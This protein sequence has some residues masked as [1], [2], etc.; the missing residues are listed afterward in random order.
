MSLKVIKTQTDYD[1]ALREIE[2]LIDLDPELGTKEAD[3]LEVL[4]LLIKAYENEQFHFDLPDPISAIKFVM[5][6]RG[7]KQADLVPFIGSRPKVSEILSGK[8][9]LSLPMMRRLH[10]GLN[11]PAEI[12]LREPGAE[13]P[14]ETNIEW[15]KLP[16]AAIYK[17]NW[18]N[19]YDESLSQFKEHAEECLGPMMDQLVKNCE[20]PVLPRAS[21]KRLRSG[22]D[23]DIYALVAWQ[24]RVI[25]KAVQIKLPASYEEISVRFLKNVA[26]LTVFDKGPLLAQELLNKNGIH[27]IIEPHFDGTFLDGGVML[28][29]DGTPVIGL[30]LRHDRLDN[31]WF[32]LLH[33]LAHLVK[34]FNG[35]KTP[36][37]DDFDYRDRRNLPDLEAEADELASEAL[38]P[39]KRWSKELSERYGKHGSFDEIKNHARRLGVHVSVLIGKIQYDSGNYGRYRD[40]LGKEIPSKL[41]GFPSKK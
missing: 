31:F 11:I 2:K 18:F 5:E 20:S 24:A 38:I 35:D 22:R 41:F 17:R 25:E 28:L 6:Q 27:L 21:I 13:L 16:L 12:L 34:H 7:L 4:S 3:R 15:Q 1:D 37:F 8:R 19:K 10:K 40:L 23:F 26:Q 30:T 14:E 9:Q 32:S 36:C 33:E 29:K 39:R